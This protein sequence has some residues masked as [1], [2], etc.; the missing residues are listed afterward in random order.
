MLSFTSSAAVNKDVTLLLE[1]V[2]YYTTHRIRA[3]L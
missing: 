1:Q 2:V 3:A